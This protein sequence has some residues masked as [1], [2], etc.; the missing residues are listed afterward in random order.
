MEPIRDYQVLLIDWGIRYMLPL[1]STGV[2][3]I[4]ETNRPQVYVGYFVCLLLTVYVCSVGK[5]S[6]PPSNHNVLPFVGNL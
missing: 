4:I 1:W 3:A 6:Q 5:V 2:L